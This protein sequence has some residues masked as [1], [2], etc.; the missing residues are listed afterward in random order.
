LSS[1]KQLSARRPRLSLRQLGEIEQE[2]CTRIICKAGF[3]LN[4]DNE[5]SKT[6]KPEMP[7]VRHR[8]A[9]AAA[10]HQAAD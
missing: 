8:L 10:R 5:S 6:R 7:D 2:T 1:T 4:D 9:G 3:Q